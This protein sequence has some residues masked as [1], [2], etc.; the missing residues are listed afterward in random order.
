MIAKYGIW[1]RRVVE[2]LSGNRA[3]LDAY[4][5][6]GTGIP[7]LWTTHIAARQGISDE[8]M[9]CIH[10]EGTDRPDEYHKRCDVYDRVTQLLLGEFSLPMYQ[11]PA[12]S[13]IITSFF[14]EEVRIPMTCEGHLC[15]VPHDKEKPV[16]VHSNYM[17]YSLAGA[18]VS[19]SDDAYILSVAIPHIRRKVTEL[20]RCGHFD[21][22]VNQR[23]VL[24]LI[25]DE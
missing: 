14:G 2:S 20:Y 25:Y 24:D 17:R 21:H 22:Q 1:L 10:Y 23:F 6:L 16:V 5:V 13:L 3:P 19:T 9:L 11:T 12:E 7:K 8:D 18:D 4:R 15:G